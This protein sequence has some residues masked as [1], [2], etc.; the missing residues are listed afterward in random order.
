MQWLLSVRKVYPCLSLEDVGD[1]REIA[2]HSLERPGGLIVERCASYN[3]F[4]KNGAGFGG[5]CQ[6]HSGPRAFR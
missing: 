5:L 3:R 4:V 1:W 6:S 2:W